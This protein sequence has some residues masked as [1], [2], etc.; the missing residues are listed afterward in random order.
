MTL[1]PHERMPQQPTQPPNHA[2]RRARLAGASVDDVV[3][4]IVLTLSDASSAPPH[5]LL[6]LTR[7]LPPEE[8]ARV[9]AVFEALLVGR[10]ARAADEGSTDAN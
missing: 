1:A 5:D 9:I 8:Q 7:A 6:A 4:H 10:A 3:A 2:A